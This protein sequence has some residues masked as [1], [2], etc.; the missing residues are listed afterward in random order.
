MNFHEVSNL[1]PLMSD[2]ELDELADDIQENGLKEAICIHDGK[3]IDGRNRYLACERAG[4]EPHYQEWDGQ[5]SL[6]S[7]VVSLNL[8][9]RHLSESQR[10]MVA[11]KLANMRSGSRTDL[12]RNGAEPPANWREVSQTEAA[13]LLNVGE[14]SVQRAKTVI[15]RGVPE[16]QQAVEHGEVSVLAASEI[17]RAPQ[18][19]QRERLN[20]HFSSSS[21]D[22][23]TPRHILDMVMAVMGEI[24]LDPCSNSKESPNVPAKYH[25]TKSDDGLSKKWF[26]RVYMNPPYGDEIPKW[27]GKLVDTFESGEVKEAIAL[28][29]A[30]TD[31]AWFNQV[32]SYT[33]CFV[34]GRLKFGDANNSAPFP[35]AVVYLGSRSKRFIKAFS[36]IG[37]VFQRVDRDVQI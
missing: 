6:V 35:S 22:H 33:I 14:R 34:R 29:P 3:I 37:P 13:T 26:G 10:A 5:G 36:E 17:A 11:G 24:D 20:V 2:E 18:E 15:D 32:C 23:N 1:F 28:L 30:R 21:D 19:K 16:L 25:Y 7:F 8:K 4:V 12:V 27:V 31:T 9:R